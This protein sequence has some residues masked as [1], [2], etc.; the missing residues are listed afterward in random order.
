MPEILVPP[1]GHTALSDPE[2]VLL[3]L[4]D[5][6]RRRPG[7]SLGEAYA[8]LAGADRNTSTLPPIVVA[9]AE[10]HTGAMI[11]LVPSDADAE[12]LRVRDGEPLD[13]LHVTL[14]Y[15]GDANAISDETRETL[16]T[17]L[18]TLVVDAPLAV[19]NAEGFA[20]SIF[21][22]PGHVK[23]DS[24][25]REPCIVLGLG[26]AAIDRART[27]VFNATRRAAGLKLPEQHAPWVPHLTLIYTDELDQVI[28]LT[29][30]VG[31]VTFDRLRLAFGGD[32]VDVPLVS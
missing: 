11:A 31:P 15:L 13:Q 5:E 3:E 25:D 16:V 21:N 17:R 9:A 30:R 12:R 26:G 22:P 32:V 18:R 24:K 23:Q 1:G 28:K 6:T 29:N 10:V 8:F 20:V 27:L 14:V 4:V 7:L 2:S 19:I